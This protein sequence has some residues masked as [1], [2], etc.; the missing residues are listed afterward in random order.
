MAVDASV[1]IR[2]DVSEITADKIAGVLRR[3]LQVLEHRTLSLA[4][5]AS[6]SLGTTVDN[7]ILTTGAGGT[8]TVDYTIQVGFDSTL[9]DDLKTELTRRI[10]QVLEAEVVAATY[11]ASFTSGNGTFQVEITVT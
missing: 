3:V 10:M 2:M 1:S 4:H 5:N 11:N 6:H 7:V 8:V 9:S